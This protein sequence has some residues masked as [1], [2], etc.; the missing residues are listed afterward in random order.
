MKHWLLGF[1]SFAT[2]GV[3]FYL[4]L[5]NAHGPSRD[6]LIVGGGLIVLAWAL[7]FPTDLAAVAQ[8]AIAAVKAWRS[9]A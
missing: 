9:N 6:V 3:G 8:S 2:A 4:L 7:A 5:A 1:A